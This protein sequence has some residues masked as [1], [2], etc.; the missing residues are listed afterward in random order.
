M[1]SWHLVLEVV[2]DGITAAVHV[3]VHSRLRRRYIPNTM[4]EY[5]CGMAAGEYGCTHGCTYGLAC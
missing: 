5:S 3:S 2:V 1:A 4:S